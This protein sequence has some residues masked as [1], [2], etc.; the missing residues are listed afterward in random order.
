MR[1]RSPAAGGQAGC[2]RKR[3]AVA[4]AQASDQRRRAH[5][6]RAHAG[7]DRCQDAA[8]D[9][10]EMGRK[11]ISDGRRFRPDRRGRAGGYEALTHP[12]AQLQ[13][14]PFMRASRCCHANHSDA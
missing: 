3:R 2:R 9:R 11:R 7:A 13:Q 12:V 4:D 14:C 8:G 10:A 6:A 1:G 5:R